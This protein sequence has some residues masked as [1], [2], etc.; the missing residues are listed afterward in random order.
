M[1]LFAAAAVAAAVVVVV[2]GIVLEEQLI[3][4]SYQSL[5]KESMFNY[6]SLPGLLFP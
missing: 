4:E 3:N 2:A 5:S 1:F 6:D